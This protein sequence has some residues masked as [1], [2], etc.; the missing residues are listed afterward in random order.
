MLRLRE[1]TPAAWLDGVDADVV[2]FLQDHAHAERKVA[3]S[4]TTLAAR[5]PQWAEL[6]QEM[7]AL[8][9]E[10]I[11]HFGQVHQLL[12]ARGEHLGW[13][14]PDPYMGALAQLMRKRDQGEHLLDRLLV[15]GVV[16]ARGCERFSLLAEG[17]SDPTLRAF[18]ATLARA[19][20]RHHALFL[21]LAK[22]RFERGVVE[23]R[24]DTILEAEAT[25]IRTLPPRVALH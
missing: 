9:L 2:P 12:V 21:R 24:L 7:V 23:E 16:E 14:K 5:H 22:T 18:Y 13:D 25:L 10:E 20:A 19:E 11:E 3:Q 6:V 8:A 4:A 17:L 1:S 15:F